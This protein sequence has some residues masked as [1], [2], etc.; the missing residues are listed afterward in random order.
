MNN[1]HEITATVKKSKEKKVDKKGDSKKRNSLGPEEVKQCKVFFK[2]FDRD[3]SGELS[4]WELRLALEAMNQ[5]PSDEDIDTI[6]NELDASK[7]GRLDF[8]EFM[9]ALSLNK[10]L[11]RK[12]D[13]EKDLVDAFVAMGGKADKSG[14]INAE[15]LRKVIKDDFGLTIKIDELLDEL[16]SNNEGFVNFEEFKTLLG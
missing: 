4:K 10:K 16:D 15:Q 2:T 9:K 5:N 13:A 11:E 1:L 6:L 3:Q 12:P 8:Q 14:F 7:N